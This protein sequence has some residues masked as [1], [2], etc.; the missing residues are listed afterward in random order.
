MQA[1][2]LCTHEMVVAVGTEIHRAHAARH[3][4]RADAGKFSEYVDEASLA[5]LDSIFALLL[6]IKILQGSKE[7]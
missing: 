2:L 5:N 4:I 6:N 7:T 1:V 3:H